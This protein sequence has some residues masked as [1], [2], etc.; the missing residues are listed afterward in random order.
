MLLCYTMLPYATLFTVPYYAL[1]WIDMMLWYDVRWCDMISY[2]P[3]IICTCKG[4]HFEA[5]FL[6]PS[7]WLSRA[8]MIS[9]NRQMEVSVQ[10]P[11]F[12]TRAR[13][14]AGSAR[15]STWCDPAGCPGSLAVGLAVSVGKT[16]GH[17]LVFRVCC[18]CHLSGSGVAGTNRS[19]FWFLLCIM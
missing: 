13:Y 6:E 2:E 19:S 12:S 11:V 5:C 17:L 18:L 16:N 9:R 3:T 10:Q 7:H 8:Q 1:I 15:A 4:V 14:I